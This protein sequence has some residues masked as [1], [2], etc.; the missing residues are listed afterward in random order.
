MTGYGSGKVCKGN[1]EVAVEITSVNR[2]S[3]EVHSS[4]PKEWFALERVVTEAV[5]NRLGRGKISISIKAKD[6]GQVTNFSWD[7]EAV[8]SLLGQL[9]N[10]ASKHQIKLELSTELL[11]GIIKLVSKPSELPQAE[12]ALPFVQEATSQA[13]ENLIKMR[14]REGEA[15][16]KDLSG[17]LDWL[18]SNLDSL[19][20]KS[21]NS[22]TRYREQL[23][24]RLKKA[25]LEIDLGDE[26]IL[27]EI[28]LFADRCDIEEEITRLRSH[29]TQFGQE[30][31][32]SGV[33]GRKMDFLCQ[34]MNREYTT[35]G[36]KAHLV[37]VTQ[38]VIDS[39]SE[40]ERIRE[41]VQN[42]E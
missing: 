8:D 35:I 21:S 27:K 38:T 34:E 7:E 33:I 9:K 14:E 19:K 24:E 30:L 20:E 40:L 36:S 12:T 2:K 18:S 42:I 39:K 3:L 25:D 15:L 5:R 23:L 1:L 22:V 10:Y 26:R 29:I 13:L 11:L 16:K 37:E 28:A 6:F 17:R 32:A 4:L 31:S 41:Q